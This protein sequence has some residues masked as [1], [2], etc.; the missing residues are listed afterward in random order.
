M[1]ITHILI[2]FAVLFPASLSF[3]EESCKATKYKMLDDSIA[4]GT[5]FASAKRTLNR[6]F[7]SKAVVLSPRSTTIVVMFH[8][9]YNNLQK[10]IYLATDGK[11]T[12][13]L[14]T[15]SDDFTRKF[16]GTADMF[17]VLWPKLK[18]KYGEQ[19]D[20]STDEA[21][22]QVKLFWPRHEGA[23]LTLLADN[24][25]IDLRIDCDALE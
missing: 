2:A 3:A 11:I 25:T 7:D 1:K 13:V 24:D 5:P 19:K 9:P 15:Y 22:D 20:L 8:Q 16:G 18:A 14:F 6:K 17:K 10:I 21:K 23:T 12:R 4:F